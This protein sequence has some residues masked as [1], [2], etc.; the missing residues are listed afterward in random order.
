MTPPI[1]QADADALGWYHTIDLGHGV[2]TKGMSDTIP[3]DGDKFPDVKGKSVLDIGAWDGY[4]SFESERRGARR[5]VALDHYV[6][7]INFGARTEYWDQCRKEGVLPDPDREETDFF[8]EGT[9]GKAGF[10]FAHAALGS[11]VEPV[12]ADFM[13][14]DL[15]SLGSFDVVLYLGVLYHIKEPFTALRRLRRV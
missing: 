4:Y 3:L 1:T 10:D 11:S 8:H 12:V 5:V 13:T 7:R 9:P 6:W 2:V 14:V 15:D